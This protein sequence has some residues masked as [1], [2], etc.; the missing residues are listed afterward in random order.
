M[1]IK[2]IRAETIENNHVRAKILVKNENWNETG[3]V[4]M[5]LDEKFNC[6]FTEIE[7]CSPADSSLF[8]LFNCQSDI[9]EMVQRNLKQIKNDIAFY[10][11][12]EEKENMEHTLLAFE[13][14]TDGHLSAW[15]PYC[16]EIHHHGSGEGHRSAHCTSQESP[17]K[18]SGYILKKATKKQLNALGL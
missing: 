6:V 18:Q 4:I 8:T 16:K 7:N 12:T 1:S 2:V 9:R 17:Y 14:N 3:V 13:R 15:C 11:H 10:L 5:L